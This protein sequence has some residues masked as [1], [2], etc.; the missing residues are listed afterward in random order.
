[1]A[2]NTIP[3]DSAEQITQA[4]GVKSLEDRVSNLEKAISPAVTGDNWFDRVQISGLVEV[5]AG[6]EKIDFTDSAAE[7]EGTGDV[8]LATVELA[9]DA[10][11]SDHIEGHV[12][13]KYEEED[14]FVDEGF[15][16]L[17]GT[18]A[19]PA[20][21]IAG[22]QYIP[23][24]NFETHFV[25]DPNPLILGETNEGAVVAGYRIGGEMID[26]CVGAFNGEIDESGDDDRIDSFVAAIS[27]RPIESLTVGASYISNLASSD[28]LSESVAVDAVNDLVGGWSAFVVF[29]LLARFKIIGEY[30]AALDDFDAGELYD[31]ADTTARK[32][33]AWHVELG[34]SIVENIEVAARYGGSKDGGAEFLPETQYG[35]VANWGFFKNTH[36]ALEYLRGEFEEDAQETDS[37]IAQLAIEF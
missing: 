32:P 31:A 26:I 24:G 16:T 33:S 27:A 18:E 19:F 12:L 11:I 36:L 4:G 21:L 1:M 6:Y 5:E 30:V 17:N 25:T 34:F 22:R 23:F 29:E 3:E 10:K 35:A 15:I 9:V 37:F 8:D 7:D 28:N 20:Y 14:V 2:Q 13:F